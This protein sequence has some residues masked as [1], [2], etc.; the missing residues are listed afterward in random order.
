MSGSGSGG[1]G[2]GG[3]AGAG[4]TDCGRL[5]YETHISSPNPSEVVKLAPGNILSIE[6]RQSRGIDV[7]QVLNGGNVVGGVVDQA[8]RIKL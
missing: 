8:Q 3:V 1:F 5:S 4:G 7:V 6:L 2:S